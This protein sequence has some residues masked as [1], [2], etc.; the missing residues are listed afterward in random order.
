[1]RTGVGGFQTVLVLGGGSEIAA[2]L[3]DR[4]R[5]DG[6]VTAILAGRSPVAE[7]ADTVFVPFD[8]LD[9]ASHPA[10][11]EDVFSRHGDIDLVVAAVGVLETRSA[12]K[13]TPALP[14]R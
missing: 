7:S 14:S 10:F 11:V 1:M 5:R 3:L 12:T 9:R 8:A 4:L 6:R 13:S 2:A